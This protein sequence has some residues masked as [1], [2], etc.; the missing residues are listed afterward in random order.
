MKQLF[1]SLILLFLL[2]GICRAQDSLH[3]VEPKSSMG[4]NPYMMPL[5]DSKEY[6]I[7]KRNKLNRTGWVLLG[8]GV[9]M[10]V[11]GT[12]IYGNTHNGDGWDQLSYEFGG[13]FLMV[14][15]SA[16][17]ITSVPIFI[18]AGYYKNKALD[19]SASLKIEPYQSGL[20]MKHYPA[21]GISIR[22]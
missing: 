20:A 2:S 8:T 9:V 7:Q 17:V 18:R 12:I 19:M 3:M 6:Y 16:L 5:K 15:G 1:S 14:A 4:K 11:T 22:L 13:V 21:I 10:G